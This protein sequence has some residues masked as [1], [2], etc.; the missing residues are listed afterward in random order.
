MSRVVGTQEVV[1]R[2]HKLNQAAL[3]VASEEALQKLLVKRVRGR[4]D[5]GV[6][7][8]GSPWPGL[9][10]STLKRKGYSSAYKGGKGGVGNQKKLLVRTGKLRDSLGVIPGSNKKLFA[11]ATGVGFRIGVNDPVASI[12]GRMHNYGLGQEKRQFIGLGALDLRSVQD[13]LNR[14]SKS[15]A[16]G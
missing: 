12:Y 6:A 1:D 9:L 13:F 11:S 3:G 2:L 8:D 16:K 7:P 4:F 14:R 5:Q 15:I 10:E